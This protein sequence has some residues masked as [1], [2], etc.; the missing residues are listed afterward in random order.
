M[1]FF[2]RHRKAFRSVIASFGMLFGLLAGCGSAPKTIR[3]EPVTSVAKEPSKA[4]IDLN[5]A[6]LSINTSGESGV[7][8]KTGT[9]GISGNLYHDYGPGKDSTLEF[10][11]AFDEAVFSVTL[12]SFSVLRGSLNFFGE[13]NPTVGKQ[14]SYR[15]TKSDAK[16]LC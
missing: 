10:T 4:S 9:T 16:K 11:F 12:D 1:G 7:F 6:G 14:Y 13:S 2:S 15:V 3:N 8:S 5:I